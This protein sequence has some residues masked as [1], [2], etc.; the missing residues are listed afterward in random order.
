MKLAILLAHQRHRRRQNARKS[1]K[2]L[3]AFQDD[4]GQQLSRTDEG[5]LKL[6]MTIFSRDE[7]GAKVEL[8][9]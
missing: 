8:G 9:N 3:R 7:H 2:A 1:L 5:Y 4:Y 6:A